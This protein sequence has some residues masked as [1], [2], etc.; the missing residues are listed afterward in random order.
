MP[1]LE[2]TLDLLQRHHRSN[3]TASRRGGAPSSTAW[4]ALWPQLEEIREASV[5]GDV[6][7]RDWLAINHNLIH[8]V[9]ECRRIQLQEAVTFKPSR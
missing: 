4:H 3:G 9:E 1:R 6:P 5:A 7:C 2:S 8:A